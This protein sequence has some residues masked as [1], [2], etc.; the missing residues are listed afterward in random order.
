MRKR[1]REERRK[2]K[3]RQARD[4][5]SRVATVA[6]C[7]GEWARGSKGTHNTTDGEAEPTGDG[8]TSLSALGTKMFFCMLYC[9]NDCGPLILLHRRSP[10]T[11][12]KDVP[13][14]FF[15][16]FYSNPRQL[17]YREVTLTPGRKESRMILNRYLCSPLSL[18]SCRRFF[19][20]FLVHL[21]PSAFSAFFSHFFSFSFSQRL[22][23]QLESPILTSGW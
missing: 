14:S 7:K 10:P 2:G 5:R 17:V 9:N 16:F 15:L 18:L 11:T 6:I 13:F 20:D 1:K 22:F 4:I 19:G 8:E 23:S 3:K 12:T 21:P